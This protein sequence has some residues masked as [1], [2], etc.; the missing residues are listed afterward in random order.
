VIA[1]LFRTLGVELL[2]V[3]E[4]ATGTEHS[5]LAAKAEAVIRAMQWGGGAQ[6]DNDDDNE[7]GA[8]QQRRDFCFLHVK[9]TDEA[10]HG[11]DPLL[12]VAVLK[13]VGTMLEQL[14]A[15]APTGTVFAMASDHSTPCAVG[16]HTSDPVAC[17]IGVKREPAVQPTAP[18][19]GFDEMSCGSNRAGLGRIAGCDLM[20]RLILAAGAVARERPARTAE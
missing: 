12:K 5:N 2:P 7:G 11:K 6:D 14:W 1:G 8:A 16:D 13:R 17:C 15:A 3:P 4:G 18:G 20:R 10:G 9:G 19:P